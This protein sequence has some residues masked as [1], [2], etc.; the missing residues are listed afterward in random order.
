MK[1]TW[2][3]DAFIKQCIAVSEFNIGRDE[4]PGDVDEEDEAA[5]DQCVDLEEEGSGMG[6]GSEHHRGTVLLQDAS[7]EAAAKAEG[8][9][10]DTD[11]DDTPNPFADFAFGK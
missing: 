9:K 6:G 3:E 2:T 4:F 7:N 8:T 1:Y 5:D 10:K 11:S